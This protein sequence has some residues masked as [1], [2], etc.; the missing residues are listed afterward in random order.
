MFTCQI[1]I[2]LQKQSDKLSKLTS[3]RQTADEKFHEHWK[4]QNKNEVK[5]YF[6][7]VTSANTLEETQIDIPQK[8]NKPNQVETDL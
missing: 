6:C 3:T 4:A 5:I 1:P 2:A 8:N 7:H